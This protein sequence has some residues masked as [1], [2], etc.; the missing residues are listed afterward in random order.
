MVLTGPGPY[1]ANL[2]YNRGIVCIGYNVTGGAIN[3]SIV[4]NEKTININ[5]AAGLLT[6]DTSP[7]YFVKESADPFAFITVTPTSLSVKWEIYVDCP[8]G[9]TCDDTFTRITND[10]RNSRNITITDPVP[11]AFEI[12]NTWQRFSHNSNSSFT[13]PA[14]ADELSA[15]VINGSYINCTKNT[16]TY[17]GFV[18]PTL[19]E[20]YE[21]EV[22]MFSTNT[23][24]D[25][26][27]LVLAY[28]VDPNTQREYSLSLVRSPYSN[29][30]CNNLWSVYYNY[31]QADSKII[32]DGT[33]SVS[34]RT[35]GWSA[36]K[37]YGVRV[38]AIR[39][40]S[41]FTCQTT[42]FSDTSTNTYIAAATLTFN[43]DSFTEL[44]KFKGQT[45]FGYGVRS[46][47]GTACEILSFKDTTPNKAPLTVKGDAQVFNLGKTIGASFC[48]INIIAGTAKVTC[49]YNGDV[50]YA[51]PVLTGYRDLAFS[52]N[53]SV[54]NIENVYIVVTKESLDTDVVWE[55]TF[56]CPSDINCLKSALGTS[57]QDCLWQT[58]GKT[59]WLCT[60]EQ[61][62]NCPDGYSVKSGSSITN[63]SAQYSYLRCNLTITTPKQICFSGKFTQTGNTLPGRYDKL[64]FY[65]AKNNQFSTTD[66]IYSIPLG[67]SLQAPFINSD[68]T[69]I[70][71]IQEYVLQEWSSGI[72]GNLQNWT[73]LCYPLSAGS[74]TLLW[75][76][77]NNNNLSKAY[78]DCFAL[79]ALPATPTPTPTVTP[80]NTP[81]VTPT[82]TPTP[83]TTPTITPTPT[84]TPTVTPTI[85]VTPTK[86]STPTPTNTR[87]DCVS[88]TS[89]TCDLT[90]GNCRTVTLRI[91]GEEDWFRFSASANV[92]YTIR[93]T[94]NFTEF[95]SDSNRG[96]AI[97][98]YDSLGSLIKIKNGLATNDLTFTS[99]TASTYF[100]SVN[101]ANLTDIGTID[102]CLYLTPPTPT[103]T[104][105][106]TTTPTPTPTVT[107]TTTPDDC[108]ASVGTVCTLNS[109]STIT[110]NIRDNTDC[111]WF[112]LSLASG[113]GYQLT[114]SPSACYVSC[115]LLNSTGAL[116]LSAGRVY[117]DR[118]SLVN[119]LGSVAGGPDA[120]V[121]VGQAYTVI[122]APGGGI[123]SSFIQAGVGSKF[124]I[125]TYNPT[126]KVKI[127]QI[128]L[129][130][131]QI[132][133]FQETEITNGYRYVVDNPMR[134]LNPTIAIDTSGGNSVGTIVFC[135]PYEQASNY[136]IAPFSFFAPGSVTTGTYYLE[137]C[138]SPTCSVA[139]NYTASLMEVTPTPTPT[140]TNTST[141]TPTVT[142]TTTPTKT[143]TPTQTPTPT[144][145]PPINYLCDN[146]NPRWLTLQPSQI[147]T[148][149]IDLGVT[150]PGTVSISITPDNP[151]FRIQTQIYYGAQIIS[152]VTN[153]V[154]YTGTFDTSFVIRSTPAEKLRVVVTN[155]LASTATWKLTVKCPDGIVPS[156]TP[157]P[158]PTTT[159]DDCT[160]NTSTTCTLTVN[161]NKIGNIRTS[162]DCDWYKINL[163]AVRSYNFSVTRDTKSCF[164][165]LTLSL[166]DTNGATIFTKS[167]QPTTVT[168][169][170]G[171]GD[172]GYLATVTS[173]FKDPRGIAV[174]NAGN[175]YVADRGNHKIH[176][177]TSTGVITTFVGSVIN[178]PGIVDGT[179]TNAR[180]SYPTGLA[181]DGN[182]DLYTTSSGVI[183]KITSLGVVTT[184]AGQPYKDGSTDGV[185][186]AA[187]FRSPNGLAIDSSGNL[188]VADSE[189]HKIRK[190][191]PSGVVTT[192][193]GTGR[194]GSTDGPATTAATFNTPAGVAVD[195]SGNVYVSDSWNHKIRKITPEGIVS[196]LAGNVE[197]DL[198]GIGYAANFSYPEGLAIDRNGDIYVADSGNHKIRKITP[199]GVVTTLAGSGAHGYFDGRAMDAVFYS[200]LGVV[201]DKTGDVYVSDVTNYRIRKI[202]Q[203]DPSG[204]QFNYMPSVAGTYYVEVCGDQQFLTCNPSG[205]YTVNAQTITN[206]PTPTVTQTNT[207]TVTQTPTS[208]STP[209]PTKPDDCGS[210]INTLCT[211][212]VN[213][214][215][216]G[217]INGDSDCDWFKVTLA[218]NQ[219]YE[220]RVSAGSTTC[221]EQLTVGLRSSI[222]AIL[223]VT[224]SIIETSTQIS[225]NGQIRC[226]NI[227]AA[228]PKDVVVNLTAG[229]TYNFWTSKLA[230]DCDTTL[231]LLDSRGVVVNSVDDG[232][233]FAIGKY[234][235]ISFTPTATGS[236]RLRAGIYG[237][238]MGTF[239]L[240]SNAIV[241]PVLA[242]YK[243]FSYTPIVADNY[244]I[245]V[246]GFQDF[247]I[248]NTTGEYTV[249]ALIPSQTPTPTSTSTPTPTPTRTLTPTPTPTQTVPLPPP[250][251]VLTLS[252]DTRT[253]IPPNTG[254]NSALRFNGYTLILRGTGL[255]KVYDVNGL[256]E[257]VLPSS[258]T[259]LGGTAMTINN[260]GEI[261]I[262]RS[263]WTI[264]KL[265]AAMTSY[266]VL[267]GTSGVRGNND[268]TG[269]SGTAGSSGTTP[270][271]RSPDGIV[272]DSSGNLYV[273]D[274]NNYCIRKILPNG[275]TSTLKSLP[276]KPV[277]LAI[278]NL[279]KIY[280]V[281]GDNRRDLV[282]VLDPATNYTVSSL[283][284][285]FNKPGGIAVKGNYLYVSDTWN[286]RIMRASLSTLTWEL[287]AG[288]GSLG[289]T[290]GTGSAAG[291]QYPQGIAVDSSGNMYVAD[292]FSCR[293]RKITPTGVV[294]TLA[295]SNLRPGIVDGIGTSARFSQPRSLSIDNTNTLLLVDNGKRL[296][297]VTTNNG[298]V[299]TINYADPY[300]PLSR[301]IYTAIMAAAGFGGVIYVTTQDDT[302]LKLPYTGESTR[303][304][305]YTTGTGYT[306]GCPFSVPDTRVLF[307]EITDMT[308]N[309]STGDVYILQ[310]R[311]G[312]NQNI[313]KMTAAGVVTTLAALPPTNWS[314]YTGITIDN[315]G[316]L[317]V[318]GGQFYLYKIT[319][320]GSVTVLA[321]N[322]N[323]RLVDGTGTAAS[324]NYPKKIVYLTSTNKLYITNNHSIRSSTLDGTVSTISG[325]VPP[326]EDS[327]T[328]NGTS[329]VGRYVFPSLIAAGPDNLLYIPIAN[330]PAFAQTIRCLNPTT[331]QVLSLYLPG[332]GNYD[333]NIAYLQIYLGVS[334]NLKYGTL[335]SGATPQRSTLSNNLLSVRY[336]EYLTGD[337]K[338][339]L[340]ALSPTNT[341]SGDIVS[342]T[343]RTSYDPTTL[344]GSDNKV[345]I[346]SIDFSELSALKGLNLFYGAYVDT[347]DISRNTMLEEVILQDNSYLSLLRLKP[348]GSTA[349]SLNSLFNLN[350]KN[351]NLSQDALVL[352]INDLPSRVGKTAGTIYVSGN[353]GVPYLTTAQKN[354]AIAKN[355]VINTL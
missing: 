21:H 256:T 267:A 1:R 17:V 32:L 56:T 206:T 221:A 155:L 240:N 15:W 336:S 296:C 310:S 298:T 305:G 16:N 322:G 139:Y 303:F 81:T 69:G 351:C 126:V 152:N 107:P 171:T 324:F 205:N 243:M 259:A 14:S 252:L 214:S 48:Y 7:H 146:T 233:S 287:V 158:T 137:V 340:Q 234:S 115:R 323:S 147:L 162:G 321:G 64:R 337:G 108:A 350:I 111:D 331:G 293:I 274:T 110:R 142:P 133:T 329:T 295:G 67:T 231:M 339:R 167:V 316:N 313:R 230:F 352:I 208:T 218:A 232:G 315:S 225:L 128:L 271:F 342:V 226:E 31:A 164:E 318:V 177:I 84:T 78:V 106:Q 52:V 18:S 223:P 217:K 9:A 170:A 309:K 172:T 35:A 343:L 328:A 105:T 24:N 266:A 182:G 53:K 311:Y 276:G 213:D 103:P 94:T 27:S 140:T 74:Y 198:D 195:S 174:D 82:V 285:N 166:K 262:S 51:S 319:P 281:Y 347:I 13:Q 26:V 114:V 129:P 39:S 227:T 222:G 189:N 116:V 224:T 186:T 86:T 96:S 118:I 289:S 215:T 251:G 341:P 203:V 144:V 120:T 282:D 348:V 286:H 220:V 50:Q 173:P 312:G 216:I 200:P 229:V 22:R 148:Y 183:R 345:R 79:N 4:Y 178:T 62:N 255:F 95:S 247:G 181:I 117:R 37:N 5:S 354:V 338:I 20:N 10:S 2:T 73:T 30:T 238:G 288:T 154:S 97:K 29:G 184:L 292:S 12:L 237:T 42:D 141:P 277:S 68:A 210:D 54:A 334:T 306:D 83:T 176:K 41:T 124:V 66:D 135:Y 149:S 123:W 169:F 244:F 100:V 98:I 300:R 127:S 153:G 125:E 284:G 261:Y 55:A 132:Y 236:Y 269:T 161:G 87:N 99:S 25:Y 254:G 33:N 65:I 157:T 175:V 325:P 160:A 85:S 196:T 314:E 249:Q 49:I 71:S 242:T 119:S 102:L 263:D 194:V 279:G 241:F 150:T 89:T 134:N 199:L 344:N 38:K 91:A 320:A 61:S 294:T 349:S 168:T 63:W 209:T 180:L 159:P 246:C 40:G 258:G 333:L 302:I 212:A 70:T 113:R 131:F 92:T 353:F 45:S 257:Q 187:S 151:A 75:E 193:A 260:A 275:C 28:Y 23:D 307:D 355:W 77:D 3:I 101:A 80:T 197:G 109:N 301:K 308:C 245:E 346:S 165:N 330:G 19:H 248:C 90:V 202:V 317:Y 211:V 138:G 130:G 270:A 60:T 143:N 179:G 47:A 327:G 291:F 201:V 192:L 76:F 6:T 268:G 88:N 188:Y 272:A 250:G 93:A 57:A 136:S 280:V 163:D 273:A 191:T 265:N 36:F 34:C 335:A 283:P 59:G 299:L 112:R 253:Y 145:T 11:N 297:T 72:G 46:Q 290:D 278:D 204:V 235:G 332:T 239:Y 185:G 326:L 44:N 104:P 58:Y 207:P 304:F 156:M 121:S 43:L 219:K 122:T 264:I 190:I 228:S 8:S